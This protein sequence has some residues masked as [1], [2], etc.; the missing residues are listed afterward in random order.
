MQNKHQT[1]AEATC[2]FLHI[3]C[4]KGASHH[5]VNEATEYGRKRI[6]NRRIGELH[7]QFEASIGMGHRNGYRYGANNGHAAN[8]NGSNSKAFKFIYLYR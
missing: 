8:H 3:Y 1:S 6:R 4:T 7:G 5:D 2:S